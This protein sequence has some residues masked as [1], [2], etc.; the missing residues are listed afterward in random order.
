VAVAARTKNRQSRADQARRTRRAITAAATR[1]FLEDG[2]LGTTMAAIAAEA[3]V[4]VQ[5][6]YLSFGSK[7]AILDTAFGQV[8]AGDDEPTPLLERDWMRTL[9]DEPDGPKALA[10]FISVSAEIIARATPLYMVIR[11]SAADPEVAVL[12]QKNKAERHKQFRVLVEALATRRGFNADLS[13]DEATAIVYVVQSEDTFAMYVNE[14]GWSVEQW[15][16]WTGRILQR[17]LFPTARRGRG[18]AA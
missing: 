6:L 8:I 1:L 9:L 15:R 4:A 14:C 7:T 2:F 12:L 17:E 10:S 16:A 11:S 3:G 18:R 5:T 13:V